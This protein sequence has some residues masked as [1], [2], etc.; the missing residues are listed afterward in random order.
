MSPKR[1]SKNDLENQLLGLLE[2]TMGGMDGKI[3][4][5]DR[6][7]G[8]LEDEIFP[9]IIKPSQLP[10]WYRDPAIIKLLTLV[11][12]AVL[13]VLFIVAALKGIKLPGIF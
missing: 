9:K 8:K 4:R 11:V 3:D 13:V 1:R 7:V 6:R 12:G 2:N 10:P 5:L